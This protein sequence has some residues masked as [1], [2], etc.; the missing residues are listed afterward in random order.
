MILLLRLFYMLRPSPLGPYAGQAS[1]VARFVLS[2]PQA[3]PVFLDRK[4]RYLYIHQERVV[5][6]ERKRQLIVAA[7]QNEPTSRREL[8]SSIAGLRRIIVPGS[9][10]WQHYIRLA[11]LAYA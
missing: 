2:E 11:N 5:Q 6:T 1:A 8:V 9:F 3:R 4:S 7:R 10:Q